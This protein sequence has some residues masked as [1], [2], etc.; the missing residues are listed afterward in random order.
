M[1]P[2]QIT[3]RDYDTKVDIWS[4]GIVLIELAEGDP[5]FINESPLRAMFMVQTS[6]E[7]RLK[8]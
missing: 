6:P 7:P 1:S 5:P 2:E 8:N 4:L 3:G